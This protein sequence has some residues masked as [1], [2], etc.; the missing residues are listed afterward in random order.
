MIIF[1]YFLYLY[2]YFRRDGENPPVEIASHKEIHTSEVACKLY[3]YIT[4]KVK[5]ELTKKGVT[6]VGTIRKNKREVTYPVQIN[7]RNVFHRHSERFIIHI[8]GSML[9]H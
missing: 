4:L 1:R 7:Q 5:G 2:L 6:I 3:Y 9:L 8:N